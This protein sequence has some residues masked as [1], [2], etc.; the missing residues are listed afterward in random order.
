[1]SP[2]NPCELSGVLR[3]SFRSLEFRMDYYRLAMSI[4]IPGLFL[5]ELT[6]LVGGGD[7]FGMLVVV[8][9]LAS[10]VTFLGAIPFWWHYRYEVGPDGV[11]G[12]DFWGRRVRL[13]WDRIDAASVLRFCGFPYALLRSHGART[14]WMPLLVNCPD[15]LTRCVD[16]Q[17]GEQHPLA[18][19]LRSQGFALDPGGRRNDGLR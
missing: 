6:M 18:A 4:L 16:L 2:G 19:A 7:L 10:V 1:M 11:H 15:A 13:E 9:A 8:P 3:I 5:G 17:V 14:L 12:Y